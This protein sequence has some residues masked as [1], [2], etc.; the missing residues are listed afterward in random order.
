MSV[1][2]ACGRRGHTVPV[3]DLRALLCIGCD[4]AFTAWATTR[5]WVVA[6]DWPG[7]NRLAQFG[8]G[9]QTARDQQRDACAHATNTRPLTDTQRVLVD[10]WH[11]YRAVAS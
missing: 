7:M 5:P 3:A 6:S 9:A 1:C 2:Q 4:A 11:H 8:H 10:A